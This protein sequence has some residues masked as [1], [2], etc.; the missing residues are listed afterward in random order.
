MVCVIIA[1]RKDVQ[2]FKLEELASCR[3]YRREEKVPL[4]RKAKR[5]GE[6][7]LNERLGVRQLV[8]DRSGHN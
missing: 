6:Q 7:S 3:A 8:C 5:R 2:K 1:K 4:K